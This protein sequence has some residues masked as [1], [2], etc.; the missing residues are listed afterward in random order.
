MKEVYLEE[1]MNLV[2]VRKLSAAL[3]KML[4]PVE[5]RILEFKRKTVLNSTALNVG[6]KRPGSIQATD[7]LL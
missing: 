1:L 5:A 3:L 6:Y 2:V 7:I 4:D